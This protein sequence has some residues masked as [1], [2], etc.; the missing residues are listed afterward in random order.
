MDWMDDP[1]IKPWAERNNNNVFCKICNVNLKVSS[2]KAASISPS[3][4]TKHVEAAK[5]IAYSQPKIDEQFSEAHFGK[6]KAEIK[7][8]LFI[9]EHNIQFAATNH[10][11]NVCQNTFSDSDTASNMALGRTKANAIITNVVGRHQFLVVCELL[12]GHPFSLCNYPSTDV[13]NTV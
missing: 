2:G 4:T 5:A 13:S 8:A 7:W 10:I 3:K 1:I 11:S 12:R 6:E 9:V